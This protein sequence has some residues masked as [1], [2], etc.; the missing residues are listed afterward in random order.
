MGSQN[1]EES[2]CREIFKYKSFQ[3]TPSSQPIDVDVRLYFFYQ[4]V[5]ASANSSYNFL[6]PLKGSDAVFSKYNT[7]LIFSR[8]V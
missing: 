5:D 7:I 2:R 3:A 8:L 4:S 6:F 1:L